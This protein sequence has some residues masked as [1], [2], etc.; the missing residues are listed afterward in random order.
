MLLARASRG[1]SWSSWPRVTA[2]NVDIAANIGRL[3]R[4]ILY[5]FVVWLA[6]WLASLLISCVVGWSVGLVEDQSCSAKLCY[7]DAR[8]YSQASITLLATYR[9]FSITC[10]DFSAIYRFSVEEMWHLKCLVNFYTASLRKNMWLSDPCGQVRQ[11]KAWNSHKQMHC[12]L[13]LLRAQLN[14]W[15]PL[16]GGYIK[17][18]TAKLQLFCRWKRQCAVIMTNNFCLPIIFRRSRL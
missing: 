14:V 1:S 3:K 15:W 6:N 17:W 9:W 10:L 7:G 16:I 12:L 8:W 2:A 4:W 18:R 5:W 13:G 11:I